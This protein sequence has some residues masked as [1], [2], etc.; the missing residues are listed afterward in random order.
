MNAIPAIPQ[1]SVRH[2]VCRAAAAAELLCLGP[3][4]GDAALPRAEG[5][6]TTE[7]VRERRQ[8]WRGAYS[9]SREGRSS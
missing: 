3:A 6:S 5:S 7:L 9:A 1:R 2:R 4:F 8:N